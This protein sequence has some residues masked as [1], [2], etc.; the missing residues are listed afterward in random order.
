MVGISHQRRMQNRKRNNKSACSLSS[1]KTK[2]EAHGDT[3][4]KVRGTVLDL[5]TDRICGVPATT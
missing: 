5:V 2:R 3:F 1:L 4:E